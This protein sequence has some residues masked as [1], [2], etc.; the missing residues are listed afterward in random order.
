[1]E[2]EFL[3]DDDLNAA[4]RHKDNLK[5]FGVMMIVSQN[6]L[7]FKSNELVEI[8]DLK[9]NPLDLE[10]MV[11]MKN[12]LPGYHMNKKHWITIILDGRVNNN[13]IFRLIDDSFKMKVK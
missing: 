11:D 10:K 3:W 9:I 5:W 8:I 12:Y 1:M 2:P 4:L 7:G 6:K 13:I